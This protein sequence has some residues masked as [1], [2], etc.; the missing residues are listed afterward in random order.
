M[1]DPSAL[2]APGY[3]L[4]ENI[5]NKGKPF[6]LERDPVTG[7]VNFNSKSPLSQ[8]EETEEYEYEDEVPSADL[9]KKENIDRRDSNVGSHRPNDVNQLVPNF[10]DFLN[11]P[12]KYNSDKYVYPLISSSYANTKVQGNVNKQYNH[13]DY[14]VT[15][16]KPTA[17]PTYYYTSKSP[18]GKNEIKSQKKEYYTTTTSTTTTTRRPTTTAA[19]DKIYLTTKEPNLMDNS[20]NIN[21]EVYQPSQKYED[22]RYTT[23]NVNNIYLTTKAPTTTK[24]PMSLFEQLFG[25]YEEVE[26]TETPKLPPAVSSTVP[27]LKQEIHTE[28]TVTSSE[29]NILTGSNMSHSMSYEYEYEDEVEDNIAVENKPTSITT[30]KSTEATVKTTKTPQQTTWEKPVNQTQNATTPAK[31]NLDYNEYDYEEKENIT[32]KPTTFSSTTSTT[33]TPSTSKVTSLPLG[34]NHVTS[35]KPT[36]IETQNLREKLNSEKVHASTFDFSKPIV[37][38]PPSTSNIHI[39][40]DQDTVSFVMGHHQ[41]VDGGK[42]VGTALKE[43]PYG[44]NNH[45]RPL[46]NQQP[47]LTSTHSASYHVQPQKPEPAKVPKFPEY[48]GSAVT[49]QP[50]KNSEASLAIGVPVNGVKQVPGQVMDEKL[51]I[52]NEKPDVPKPSGQ[53]VVFPD[54]NKQPAY[55]P[56]LVPPPKHVPPNREVLKLNSKPMFHQLP[57]D[58]TPPSEKD[59]TTPPRGERPRPPWDPRPGHFYSGRPEYARPPRPPPGSELAYKRIDNLPNI[60]PQFRPN[61]KIPNAPHHYF[62]NANGN[63]GYVRQPLLERPSNRPVGF[64]EK[65]HPPP[66]PKHL[67]NLRKIPSL[68]QEGKNKIS[69]AEDRI[70]VEPLK[71]PP[72]EP[73][74]FFQTPPKIVLPNRRSGNEEPEVETLQM[75]QAKQA[76]KQEVTKE[77]AFAS[78]KEDVTDKPLYVVYPVNTAP[79]KLDAIDTNKKETV[80]IGTRAELP[81]PPSKIN[82]KDFNYE[83]DPILSPK[84]RHDSPILKPHSKPNIPNK[85]DFPYPLERPDPSVLNPPVPET[86]S[87][88]E[89][90]LD[91]ADSKYGDESNNQWSETQSRIVTGSKINTQS[92]N[93][94]SVTLKTYT[95]RPIAVAYTPTEPHD[96]YADKY[97]MP[98]YASPVIPE[99]R[100]GSVSNVEIGYEKPNS[101]FTLSAVM[102]TRPRPDLSALSSN[103]YKH[104]IDTSIDTT[105][106]PAQEFQAP[107]QA[108]V[109]IDSSVSQGWSVVRDRS[110]SDG[111]HDVE[112]TTLPLATTSEFDIENFKPQLIGGFVPIYSYPEDGSKGKDVE[113]KERQ[114]KTIL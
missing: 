91:A 42:Y 24:R 55:R 56:D 109:N 104:K 97:S 43:S 9:F 75:I 86:Q 15:T 111:E 50:L 17:S 1:P 100:P 70:H 51:E 66:P 77:A 74:P 89:N 87:S 81:L 2:I 53:K 76:E 80:V 57:S 99:I 32:T 113:V 106:V 105:H 110:K 7:A 31:D 45:F 96:K 14:V 95:E 19:I 114:E 23:H 34:E 16:Y 6:Y 102:H 85:S 64:F 82:N 60:L 4:P 44:S 62:E 58:L 3:N 67:Q 84:D 52:N 72:T 94:I 13:K 27:P 69:N 73:F 65:L 29:S 41:S 54:D 38:H 79:L 47:T 10:H 18:Y 39:A 20:M 33:Q 48:A 68:E 112:V 61:M 78:N 90:T 88:N 98:N 8:V 63:K 40:P 11:L 107:F 46:Y 26:P 71:K 21:K 30:A 83:Q 108:S 93:Q 28:K 5:F 36:I 35:R 25:E 49:I 22:S 103:I 101:E 59:L 12:V 92:S 37:Q